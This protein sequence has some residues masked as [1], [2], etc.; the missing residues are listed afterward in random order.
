MPAS[1]ELFIESWLLT[2][3]A[4]KVAVGVTDPCILEEAVK[5]SGIGDFG[6]VNRLIFIGV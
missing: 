3:G 2:E 4:I 5:I 1:N 6:K